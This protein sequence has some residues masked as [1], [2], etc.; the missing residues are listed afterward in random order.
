MRMAN[1]KRVLILAIFLSLAADVS[2]ALETNCTDGIDDDSDT[3]TDC[4]DTD[5]AGLMGPT[6]KICCP[7]GAGD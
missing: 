7:N 4:A 5:C 3:F 1:I 6:G 2:L